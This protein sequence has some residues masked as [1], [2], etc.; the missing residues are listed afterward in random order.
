M[1]ALYLE[2][3][4][5]LTWLLGETNA[6]QVRTRVDAATIIVTSVLTLLET[7]RT[8]IRAEQQGIIKAAQR[9]KLKGLLRRAQAAWI[10]MEI[11]AEVR[12][13]AAQPF[14]VEPVRTLDAI[15]LSTAMLFSRAYPDLTVL[16]FDHR[17]TSNLEPLGLDL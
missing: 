14:P 4:A 13:L 6:R 2:S 10:L 1:A 8:L 17:I 16:S 7:D 5:V 11:T 12:Q 3:S 15:H 9:Q